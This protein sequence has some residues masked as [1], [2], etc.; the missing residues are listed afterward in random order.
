MDA[1]IFMLRPFFLKENTQFGFEN[2]RILCY[3]AKSIDICEF[4]K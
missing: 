3:F 1:T 4:K 2:T